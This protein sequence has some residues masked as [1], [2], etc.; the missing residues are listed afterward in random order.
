[1]SDADS[2]IFEFYLPKIAAIL[3]LAGSSLIM[4]EVGKDMKLLKQQ[5]H[6]LGVLGAVPRILLSMSVGDVFSSL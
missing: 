2:V 6:Q 5:Q 1:M 3:S 4:A